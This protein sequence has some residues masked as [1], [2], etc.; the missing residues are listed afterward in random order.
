MERGSVSASMSEKL[1]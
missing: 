1:K